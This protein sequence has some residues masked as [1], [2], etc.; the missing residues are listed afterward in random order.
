MAVPWLAYIPV[1]GLSLLATWSAPDDPL[2]RYHAR[3][4]GLLVVLL[5]SWL[6]LVGFATGFSDAP[7]YLATMGLVAGVPMAAGLIGI[8]WGIVAAARG[9]YARIRPVWDIL[10]LVAK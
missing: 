7:A 9:R 1:P 2:T 8:V 10:V 6:L 4:G 3:Q 5:W